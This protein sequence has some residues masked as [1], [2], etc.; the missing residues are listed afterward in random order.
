[1]H[2]FL[3]WILSLAAVAACHYAILQFVAGSVEIAALYHYPIAYGVILITGVFYLVRLKLWRNHPP[4][5]PVLSLIVMAGWVLF[6][7]QH[8]TDRAFQADDTYM[9]DYLSNAYHVRLS[10][11][12]QAILAGGYLLVTAA[13]TMESEAFSQAAEVPV[14]LYAQNGR[15]VAESTLGM[16]LERIRDKTGLTASFRTLLVAEARSVKFPLHLTR[17]R[18]EGELLFIFTDRGSADEYHVRI[19]GDAEGFTYHLRNINLDADE[20][21]REGRL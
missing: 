21:D 9:R 11:G 12:D 15:K 18:E 1:M 20:P 3:F 13:G 10:P 4:A 8:T 17:T 16:L 5:L 6:A 7:H 19:G 2:R 14:L